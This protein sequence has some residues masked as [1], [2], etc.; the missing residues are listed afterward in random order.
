MPFTGCIASNFWRKGDSAS[1]AKKNPIKYPDVGRRSPAVHPEKI[2][3][4]IAPKIK[5][6]AIALSERRGGNMSASATTTNVCNVIGT[7]VHGSGIR[8]SLPAMSA[9][10]PKVIQKISCVSE[11]RCDVATEVG[12][13][14]IQL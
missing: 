7:G 6:P 2:G 9:I 5:Y 4:P 10:T 14:V 1:A 8:I 3:T 11:L 13:V 12:V